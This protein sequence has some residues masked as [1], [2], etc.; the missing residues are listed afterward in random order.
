MKYP[1][2]IAGHTN[3]WLNIHFPSL[4]G[5]WKSRFF[6]W[7]LGQRGWLSFPSSST[8]QPATDSTA[9]LSLSPD[10]LPHKVPIIVW[11]EIANWFFITGSS[12]LHNFQNVCGSILC[13]FIG[14]LHTHV[15]PHFGPS[16]S[17]SPPTAFVHWHE[18][19]S[20]HLV[21]IIYKTFGHLVQE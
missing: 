14:C 6:T 7:A 5:P 1:V 18:E 12:C 16:L 17:Y 20:T 10:K 15:L 21:L 4:P 9:A 13:G 2:S 3:G 19:I 11:W 8:S